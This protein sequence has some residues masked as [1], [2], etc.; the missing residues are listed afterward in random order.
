[1]AAYP[2]STLSCTC[3]SQY[4]RVGNVSQLF[5]E[6]L[7]RVESDQQAIEWKESIDNATTNRGRIWLDTH[8]FGSTFPVR[9][10]AYAHW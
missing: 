6:L 1:M 9:D 2:S 4:R 10:H 5:R 7:L 8:Q 3:L